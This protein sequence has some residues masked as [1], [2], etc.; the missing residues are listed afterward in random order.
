MEM[1]KS[2]DLYFETSSTQINELMI[3][4]KNLEKQKQSDPISLDTNNKCKSSAQWNESK[5]KTIWRINEK[6]LEKINRT[7]KPLANFTKSNKD[8]TQVNKIRGENGDITRD[9]NEIQ[10]KAM[11]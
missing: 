10:K 2:K 3:F 6:F 1:L 4:C 9:T 7:S 5:K 11:L 8:K